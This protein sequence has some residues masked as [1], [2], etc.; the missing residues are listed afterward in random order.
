M[1]HCIQLL[2]LTFESELQFLHLLLDFEAVY[3][4]LFSLNMH[5]LLKTLTGLD[6]DVLHLRVVSRDLLIDKLV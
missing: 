6:N 3:N 1:S 2:V 5:T 4:A